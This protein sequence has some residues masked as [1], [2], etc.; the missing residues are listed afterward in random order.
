MKPVVSIIVP[1]YNAEKVM[2]KCIESILSQS[3]YQIEV[4]L[5]DDGSTD[6][7]R[8]IA[9]EY[10]KKDK[11]IKVIHQ[12]N[13]GVSSARN[14][15]LENANGDFIGFV[16]ADDWI[17]KDMYLEMYNSA[18]K[19]NAD[20]T[21]CGY[22]SENKYYGTKQLIETPLNNG[23]YE[24]DDII[25][26]I[27]IPMIGT[28]EKSK[29]AWNYRVMGSVWRNIFRKDLL[30]NNKI[31]FNKE[32]SYCED[33]LFCIESMSKCNRLAIVNKPFYH[34]QTFQYSLSRSYRKNMLDDLITVDEIIKDSL[35]YDI[36]QKIFKYRTIVIARKA[37]INECVQDNPATL[38]RKLENIDKILNNKKVRKAYSDINL[39]GFRHKDKIIYAC[40][41][42]KLK[43]PL[44]IY[45]T[46]RQKIKNKR[47][48]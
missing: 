31:V 10:K 15:G 47:M 48:H 21:M 23:V 30:T 35:E 24:K 14:V 11:R 12:N 8:K 41:K 7:T 2:K 4:I 36:D 26:N 17:D 33:L 16:D 6:N 32:I 45:Y 3:L 19:S 1:L 5:I 13:K 38:Y 39:K 29:I 20:I 44:L 43:L 27:I 37:I 25:S 22:Y 40:I 9:E 46:L 34:Y 28:V 42:Y 18:I